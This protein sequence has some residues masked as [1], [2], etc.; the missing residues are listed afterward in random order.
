V[1]LR[2]EYFLRHNIKTPIVKYNTP[3]NLLLKFPAKSIDVKWRIMSINVYNKEGDAG[4]FD[5][6]FYVPLHN[7]NSILK[8]I[9]SD[10][11]KDQFFWEDYEEKLINRCKSLHLHQVVPIT[12]LK[13][14]ELACWEILLYSYDSF[15]AD[16]PPFIQDKFHR[17]LFCDQKTKELSE[18]LKTLQN[19][20]NKSMIKGWNSI[21][22]YVDPKSYATWIA[23]LI[24][25][26]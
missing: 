17:V 1:D 10:E 19:L 23:Q 9:I 18:S 15:V 7:N 2:E 5:M 22:Q 12:D 24:G 21:K 6:R 16:L 14:L 3:G 26:K 13:E 8:A 25:D 20:E 4:R 11:F